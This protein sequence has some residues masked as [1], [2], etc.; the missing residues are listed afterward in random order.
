MPGVVVVMPGPD[1]RPQRP[2]QASPRRRMSLSGCRPAPTR[3]ESAGLS[4]LAEGSGHPRCLQHP[5][6]P[7]SSYNSLMPMGRGVPRPYRTG[8]RTRIYLRILG[9][10]SVLKIPL[11]QRRSVLRRSGLRAK[12]LNVERTP[13]LKPPQLGHWSVGVPKLADSAIL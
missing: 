4:G 6:A 12:G 9:S 1:S 7:D 3:R 5:V 10:S 13:I 11:R 8:G 2:C